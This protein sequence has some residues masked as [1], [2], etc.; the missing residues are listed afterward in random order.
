MSSFV[1]TAQKRILKNLGYRREKSAPFNIVRTSDGATT[2]QKR[3][4][5]SV[6]HAAHLCVINEPVH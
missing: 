4:P 6:A 5:R 3:W 1:R 2:G